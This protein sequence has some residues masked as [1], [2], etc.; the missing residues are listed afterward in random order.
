MG[1]AGRRGGK[2]RG[3]LWLVNLFFGAGVAPTGPLLESAAL[4]FQR[5]GWRVEVLTGDAA[6]NA[7]R[8]QGAQRF[9]GRVHRLRGGGIGAKGL[10]GRLASWLL[11]YLGVA[12][13]AFTHRLP[14]RVVCMTTPPFLHLIF[15]L[16]NYCAARK[17]Q[18]ILWNQDTYPEVLASVGL[19]RPTSM[20]YRLLFALQRWATSR[21]AHAIALDRAMADLLRGHGAKDVC[22]IPNFDLE[23]PQGGELPP[24]ELRACVG[25]ARAAYR[26]LAL[27]TGNYGWG[28]DLTILLQWLRDHPEQRTLFCLFVGGGEKWADLKALEAA[29]VPGV[30]AFP[31]VPRPVVPALLAAANLGLVC[32]E[33]GCVGLMSPSKIHGYL[34][35]GK[36]LLYLGPPG[37]NVADALDQYGCGWRVDEGDAAGLERLLAGLAAGRHDLG[38]A[39][40]AARRAAAERYTEAVAARDL[41]ALVGPP[42]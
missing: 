11:F 25:R 23:Y 22:I 26:H 41:A 12:V 16:R 14:A 36:P 33:K 38:A 35:A 6:Y 42:E 4:A 18:V 5:Q 3:R 29:G 2:D 1:T 13:F 34:A 32:L 8:A 39:A 21:V 37:S 15:T 31:Y 24:G 28:H 9:R 19:L 10:G 27:Y 7:A 17:T 20:P 40:A 30:A